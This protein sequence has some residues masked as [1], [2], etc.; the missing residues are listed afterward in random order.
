MGWDSVFIFLAFQQNSTM[1]T[2]MATDRPH[3]STTKTPPM[4]TTFSAEAEHTWNE[5]AINIH[6]NQR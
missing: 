4:F 1:A 5:N 2:R 3:N 6:H